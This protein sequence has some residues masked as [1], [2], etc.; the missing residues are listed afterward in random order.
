[1]FFVVGLALAARS[2]SV[3]SFASASSAAERLSSISC[4]A[5]AWVFSF[6][7]CRFCSAVKRSV[8][9]RVRLSSASIWRSFIFQLIS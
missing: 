4:S 9:A 8:W 2:C 7:V 5:L 6:S 3:S 1:M